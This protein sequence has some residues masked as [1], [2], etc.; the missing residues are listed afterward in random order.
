M[1]KMHVGTRVR[2]KTKKL[3]GKIDAIKVVR[4]EFCQLKYDVQWPS[5]GATMD[6]K[7]LD[8]QII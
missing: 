4:R 1:T 7:K 8:S 6:Y 5:T 3:R 2:G